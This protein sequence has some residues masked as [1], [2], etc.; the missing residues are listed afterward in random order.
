VRRELLLGVNPDLFDGIDGSTDSEL[1]FYLALTFGLEDDPLGG[2]ERA[3]GFM[4][5]TGYGL[6]VEHPIQM[7]VGITDGKR[8]WAARYSSAHRS[9]TLFVSQD[10][11]TLR[12]LH[13]EA[14]RLQRL[15]DEDRVIVSEP[16]G[17]LSGAWVEVPESTA[18]IVQPGPDE[19]RPFRPQRP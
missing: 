11:A 12:A 9:R 8:V 4:E 18:V 5:D 13:P 2:L 16:L 3:V 6:G 1:L 19:K 17:D 15:T 7:T 10:A 14:P